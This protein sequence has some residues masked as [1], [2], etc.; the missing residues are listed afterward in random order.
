M[1]N[2]NP[3]HNI[4]TQ[5]KITHYPFLCLVYHEDQKLRTIT[6]NPN[7]LYSSLKSMIDNLIYYRT[8]K[9]PRKPFTS[10]I[11][12]ITT[13][14][15]LKTKCSP[16]TPCV[17]SFFDATHDEDGKNEERFN[18]FMDKIEAVQQKNKFKDLNYGWVN[19][20]CEQTFADNS[21]LSASEG[22]VAVFLDWK[23]IFSRLQFP[24][25]DLRL[26]D[27]FET[28]V[29]NR[30]VDYPITP[31]QFVLEENDCSKI[32]K[33]KMMRDQKEEKQINEEKKN[34]RGFDPDMK[35]DL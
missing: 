29:A 19:S 32:S 18:T 10:S 24:V 7:I 26:M 22:G 33:R 1:V 5:Y 3:D 16:D 13:N 21:K 4:V 35:T 27:Y 15:Q 25:D 6:I 30:A 8:T 34:A 2:D 31:E 14:S 20:T 28:A 17:L 23:N 12:M 11:P 9:E